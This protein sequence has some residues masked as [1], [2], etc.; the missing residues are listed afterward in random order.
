MAVSLEQSV[1]KNDDG[2]WS[3]A[4][5]GFSDSWCGDFRGE[6]ADDKLPF[7]SDGWPTKEIAKARGRQHFTEHAFPDKV[8]PTLEEFRKEHNL[9]VADDGSVSVSELASIV[10][11]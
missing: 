11:D 6:H 2:T 1:S 3:F 4:C 7:H 8:T 9:V 10:E 5:P